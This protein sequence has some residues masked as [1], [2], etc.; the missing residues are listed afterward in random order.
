MAGSLIVALGLFMAILDNT[1]VSVTF[2]PML[3]AFQT[4]FATIHL[5][6]LNCSVKHC[7]ICNFSSAANQDS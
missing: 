7:T 4:D 1:I 2:P 3:K 6:E 5:R